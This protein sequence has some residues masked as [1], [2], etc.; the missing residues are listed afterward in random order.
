MNY[1]WS[2]FIHILGITHIPKLAKTR[3]YFSTD[4]SLRVVKLGHGVIDV[5]PVTEATSGHLECNIHIF[6]HFI[7]LWI[8]YDKC[9]VWHIVTEISVYNV[10]ASFLLITSLKIALI[11]AV[12]ATA[13][14]ISTVIHIFMT[15]FQYHMSAYL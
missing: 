5:L 7:D 8:D 13:T 12:I 4:G 2:N 11:T 9:R 10:L 3:I 14:V 15:Y 6:L 1:S